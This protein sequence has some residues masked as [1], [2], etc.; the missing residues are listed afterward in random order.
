MSVRPEH[1]PTPEDQEPRVLHT[2]PKKRTHVPQKT[3]VR[4]DALTVSNAMYAFQGNTAGHWEGIGPN[5]AAAQT[6]LTSLTLG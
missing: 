5:Y 3:W 4:W 2:H 6:N 1:R